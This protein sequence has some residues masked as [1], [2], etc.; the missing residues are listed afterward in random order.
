MVVRLLFEVVTD[1]DFLD[2]EQASCYEIAMEEM[3]SLDDSRLDRH[4][5]SRRMRLERR[6]SAAALYMHWKTVECW[7]GVCRLRKSNATAGCRLGAQDRL[8]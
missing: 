8:G 3:A 1:Q 5:Q 4:S 2:L 7:G 6:M